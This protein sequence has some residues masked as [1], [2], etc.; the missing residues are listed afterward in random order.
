MPESTVLEPEFLSEVAAASHDTGDHWPAES[1][2]LFQ[3]AGVT[4]LGIPEVYGG[5]ADSVDLTA[6]YVDLAAADLS[7]C[8]ILTQQNSAVS[9]LLDSENEGPKSNWLPALAA[10]DA[11]ATVGISHLTTSRQHV[12]EPPVRVEQTADGFRLNGTVPWS[13]AA[14]RAQMVVV[15]GTCADG[16]EVL[17]AVD[18]DQ[19]G[20]QPGTPMQLLALTGSETGEIHLDNVVAPSS[21]L[22]AGPVEGVMRTGAGGAGSL[23][24]SALAV[25]VSQRAV[26]LLEQE[27]ESREDVR[28]VFE[29][30]SEE[31]DRVRA[32]LFTTGD[33]KPS[34]AEIRSQ[35]NSLALRST[36]AL[37]TAAKGAGFVQGHPA[38]RAVREAMFF[39]VWSCPRPVAEAAMQ[40]FLCRPFC[41][42]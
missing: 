18:T 29:P 25:G 8:F 7:A 40:E 4:A 5:R 20:W 27:S 19:P 9:R 3:Q 2:R 1:L 42:A 28:A 21:S 17:L 34:T 16:Q 15:G 39:L 10:G 33:E 12:A 24:T 31:L 32:L 41:S 30:L 35:A 36:Q 37:M 38:E 6:A 26:S 11:L 23:T 14:T 13:T 22:L